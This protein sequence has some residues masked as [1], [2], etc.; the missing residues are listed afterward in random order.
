MS[1]GTVAL[2]GTFNDWRVD[3]PH[4]RLDRVSD[5]QYE[6]RLHFPRGHH[7][8]KWVLKGEDW[9]ARGDES[10]VTPTRGI[11]VPGG[12]EVVLN[13]LTSG[14]YSVNIDMRT[15]RWIVDRV[16]GASPLLGAFAPLD[17]LD[18]PFGEIVRRLREGGNGP[19]GYAWD[20]WHHV[21][22]FIE[23]GAF[24]GFLPIREGGKVLFVFNASLRQ[25]LFLAANMNGWAVGPDVFTRVPGTDVHLLYREY[26]PDTLLKYKLVHDGAW[27]ADPGN[28]WVEP[29][30]L[31]VPMFQTGDFNSVLDLGAPGNERGD[32]LVRVCFPSIV[33]NHS[34]DVWIS[35]P[36]DYWRNPHMRYPVL[37]VNDGNEALTRSAMHSLARR[38]F[39]TGYAEP[40][41]LVFIGL[42]NQHE[43]NF[44]YSD[45]LGRAQYADFVARELVPFIDAAF[46]T[47]A[48]ATGRGVVGASF[49]GII[50]YYIGWRHAELFENVAG[51]GTSFFAQ[52]WDV[53]RLY[54]E[55]PR[56]RLKLYMDSAVPSHA[57]AP[58]D[59][60]LSSRY[61]E[62]CLRA[63][64]YRVTHLRRR[65][66]RHEWTSWQ[67]RFPE[68][69]HTFWPGVNR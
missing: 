23:E 27:F 45:P 32:H 29:D 30:G 28:L 4:A 69:L 3:D 55:A 65:D 21:R 38:T 53:L 5:H 39:E 61:A 48:N 59:N 64:G 19:F 1:H 10:L 22:P 37:Y 11:A 57:R 33:R 18:G 36:R 56:L 17:L 62:R 50:S 6:A 58:R 40:C 34:R 51:Q 26:P 46:R 52:D 14:S 35:V 66:Q 24:R 54:T 43:R 49:G 60:Y 20:R 25:P 2:S 8:F 16:E 44:E 13:I 47:Q 67:E 7:A 42:A 41:L 68:V 12:R 31:P 15:G 63:A 9:G